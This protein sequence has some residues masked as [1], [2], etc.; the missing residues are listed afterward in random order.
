MN[1]TTYS[2]RLAPKAFG[3]TGSAL[4]I[5]AIILMFIDHVGAVIVEQGV[6]RMPEV[7]SV[8]RLWEQIRNIDQVIRA[9]GRPAFPIFCFLLVEGFLHT[10]NRGKYTLR[11]FLFALVSEIPFDLA[12]YGHFWYPEKQNVFFTLLIGLL[13]MIACT[14]FQKHVWLQTFFL[15]LGLFAGHFLGTDYGYK[16]VFLIEILY[17]LRSDRRIQA[18]GGALAISWELTAPLAFIPI[19]FYNGLRGTSLK[20]FFY[21]FYPV[22]LLLLVLGRYLLI[23]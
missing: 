9:I 12:I 6:L 10:H 21:W 20:Y 1:T 7:T 22:H 16:G 4:K 11:L 5:I 8:P 3:L 17:L 15:A 2:P 13:V 14:R 23:A 19:W 18:L